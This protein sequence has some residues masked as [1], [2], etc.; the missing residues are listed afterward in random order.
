VRQ[1]DV[2]RERIFPSLSLNHADFSLPSG[3][4]ITPSTAAPMRTSSRSARPANLVRRDHDLAT[5]PIIGSGLF[6]NLHSDEWAYGSFEFGCKGWWDNSSSYLG[7]VLLLG[8]AGDGEGPVCNDQ[9]AVP[10]IELVDRLLLEEHCR[11]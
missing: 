5:Q 2:E 10:G 8:S 9:V 6:Q 7:L 3:E 4:A 1:P 11:A